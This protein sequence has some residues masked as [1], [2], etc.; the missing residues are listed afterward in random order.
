MNIEEWKALE[1]KIN[2]VDS[3]NDEEKAEYL[4]DVMKELEIL[5]RQKGEDMKDISLDEALIA[6]GRKKR[7]E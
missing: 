3:M 7:G 1:K 2:D 4:R 6:L 5:K